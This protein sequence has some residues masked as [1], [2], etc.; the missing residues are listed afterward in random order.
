MGPVI[1]G[2][3]GL[4]IM[5]LQGVKNEAGSLCVASIQKSS[6]NQT[7]AKYYLTM[8]NLFLP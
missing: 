5:N 8:K 2:L 3:V 7:V 4:Y 6:S 1:A